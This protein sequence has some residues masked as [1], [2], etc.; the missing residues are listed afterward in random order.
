MKGNS[1]A[2][3]ESQ[4]PVTAAVCGLYCDACSI[5]IGTHEEPKRLEWFAARV[6]W[7]VEQARCEGCRSRKRTPYCEA[8]RLYRCAE[9]RGLA[10]CGECEDYPCAELQAFQ[11]E[12]PHRA[13]LW[14]NLARIGEIGSKAWLD[15]VRQR[16]TCP[17]CGTLNS[18]Y[19]LKCRACGCEPSCDYVATHREAILAASSPR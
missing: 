17:S 7:D 4:A 16:Y 11:C 12:Q 1:D 15:E 5:F 10:F 9:E 18:A 13:E 3:A 8:C 6:G 2:G 19:D 14:E